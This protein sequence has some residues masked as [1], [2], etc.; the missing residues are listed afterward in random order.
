MKYH[1]I[2]VT[3]QEYIYIY[4][5]IKVE[6]FHY[7]DKI[8]LAPQ[9]G[10]ESLLKIL[11]RGFYNLILGAHTTYLHQAGLPYVLLHVGTVSCYD[12]VVSAANLCLLNPR[13]FF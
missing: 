9:K 2:V 3:L 12:D 13:E 5:Y 7:E 10:Q 11:A 8:I 4:I 1:A 6:I